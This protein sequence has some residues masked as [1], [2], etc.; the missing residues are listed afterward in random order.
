MLK[1]SSSLVP[2]LNPACDYYHQVQKHMHIMNKSCHD[3]VVWTTVDINIVLI[4]WIWLIVNGHCI[5]EMS[6]WWPW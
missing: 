5:K 4:H 3:F 6:C 1:I 2:T